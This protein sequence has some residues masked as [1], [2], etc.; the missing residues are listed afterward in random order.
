M[1]VSAFAGALLR[2]EGVQRV[3][4]GCYG[5]QPYDI[6]GTYV[7]IRNYYVIA[8]QSCFTPAEFT[9]KSIQ[10][11]GLAHPVVFKDSKGLGLR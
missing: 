10:E 4:L 2:V 7:M 6:I 1:S 3:W 5:Y 11:R 9:L 8:P